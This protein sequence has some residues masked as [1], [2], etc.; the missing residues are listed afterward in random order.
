MLIFTDTLWSETLQNGEGSLQIK[1]QL[2]NEVLSGLPFTGFP[3]NTSYMTLERL[4]SII[5]NLHDFENL[6]RKQ[7]VSIVDLNLC[8]FSSEISLDCHLLSFK[9]AL[10]MVLS[11]YRYLEK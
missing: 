6:Y 2:S 8:Y 1:I 10:E 9:F 11:E 7:Y 4:T 3:K 5:I